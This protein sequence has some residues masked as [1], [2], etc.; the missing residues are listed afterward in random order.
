MKDM[1]WTI[2]KIDVIVEFSHP[3][4]IIMIGAIM[5][6]TAPNTTMKKNEANYFLV[7][8]SVIHNEGGRETN[9]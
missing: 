6:V 3:V 7:A 1:A 4:T 2:V 9:Q 5:S 8:K